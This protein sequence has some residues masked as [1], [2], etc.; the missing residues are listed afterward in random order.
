MDPNTF[1]VTCT[2]VGHGH[3]DS[4]NS[5]AFSRLVYAL[6]TCIVNS[7]IIILWFTVCEFFM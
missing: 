3:T 1:E 5:V 7:C 6:K 2:A 4:V